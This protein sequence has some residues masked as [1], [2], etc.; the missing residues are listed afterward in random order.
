M[1]QNEQNSIV[2]TASGVFGGVGRAVSANLTGVSLDG[3]LE[4]AIYAAISAIV[5]YGVKLGIDKIKRLIKK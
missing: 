4:V 2:T 1:T 5:G 3:M